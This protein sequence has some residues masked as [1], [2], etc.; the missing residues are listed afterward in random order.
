MHIYIYIYIYIYRETAGGA[1]LYEI[2]N[3]LLLQM[4]TSHMVRYRLFLFP[5]TAPVR[6]PARPG[7]A[8]PGRTRRPDLARTGPDRPGRPVLECFGVVCK[9]YISYYNAIELT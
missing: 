3:R 9:I 7:P 2:P 4:R 1:V 8:R 6:R 5:L